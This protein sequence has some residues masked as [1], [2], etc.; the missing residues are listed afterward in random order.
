MKIRIQK[1]ITQGLYNIEILANI[2]MD[3][4][5]FS[6][7]KSTLD[8]LN[9][10]T[11]RLEQFELTQDQLKSALLHISK[12]SKGEIDESTISGI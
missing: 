10:I 11:E 5:Y 3:T 8:D 1:S 2:G 12:F 9:T 6:V 7:E 4:K